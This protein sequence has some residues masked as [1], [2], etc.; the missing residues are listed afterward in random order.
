MYV[1][2]S[3]AAYFD[4]DDIGL[5]GFAAYFKQNSDEEREHA[6]KLMVQQNRRGGR[7]QLQ[8]SLKSRTRV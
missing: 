4:R 5:P 2:H 3:L 8:V 1:Y 6:N 7:V